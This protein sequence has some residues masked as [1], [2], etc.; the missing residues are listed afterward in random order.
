M[1]N[2]SKP[3]QC[4]NNVKREAN[5]HFRSKKTKYLQTKFEEHN[6]NSKFK[7]IMDLN[8]G[9]NDFKNGYQPRTNIVM[10]EKGD[11]ITDSHD[12]LARWRKYFSQLMNAEWVNLS[13]EPLVPE[14]NAFEFEMA[15]GNL[16]R[17]KSP[18]TNQVPVELF[19]AGGRTIGFDFH[20][21]I[22]SILNKVELPELLKDSKIVLFY[23]RV[24]KRY[25]SNHRGV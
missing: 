24:A 11:L 20:K 13:A 18:G 5:R 21:L 10:D 12:I 17:H 3:K 16:K 19:K 14:P 7:N 15:V 8:R 2:R 1:V 23:K 4:L 25:C 9:I 6:T 22:I